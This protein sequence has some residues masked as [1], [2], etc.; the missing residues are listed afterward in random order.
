MIEKE[1]IDMMDG[2]VPALGTPLDNNGNL[3]KDSLQKQIEDQIRAGAVGL[4]CM[5]SMGIQAFIRNDVYPQVAKAAVEAAA[6]R[7]PV[8]VGAMDTSIAR[9]KE[10][11]AAVEDLDIAGFV[12]TAPYYSPASRDQMMRFFKGVAAAT[13]HQVLLYD[14]PG[15]TQCKITYD[16]VLELI[17]N[18]P[19]MAGIKSADLQMFRKLKLNPEVP[20]NFIMVYSGLDTFDIAYKWGITNCLDGML[21]CTP[22]NTKKM[23]AAMAEGDYG[24]AAE[25]LNR[26]VALRDF[27][28]SHDLWP[29]FTAAMNLLG[30]E[31]IYGPD[32]VAEVQSAS[33]EEIRQEMNRIGE[34]TLG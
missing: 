33:V 28:V 21:S 23:F 32:Y 11:M 29:S 3:V 27:F 20:E 19:N 14:L 9:A 2:F 30:Y 1:V 34:L 22:A 6:G 25:C 4:L 5:G 16:M 26:I 31:G 17:R 13:K 24:T 7:V 15:V 8:Y 18:V 10:R 12:F